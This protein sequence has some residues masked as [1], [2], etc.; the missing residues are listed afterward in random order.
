MWAFLGQIAGLIL[1]LVGEYIRARAEARKEQRAFEVD[2]AAFRSMVEKVITR[3]QQ[4]APGDS[5]GAGSG[6]DRAD[7]SK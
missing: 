7:G 2:Q 6:W 4:A 5:Q 1:S 3:N